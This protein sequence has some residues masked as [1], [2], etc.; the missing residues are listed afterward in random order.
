MNFRTGLFVGLIA[1]FT[2]AG[3]VGYFFG[4]PILVE[5][6]AGAVITAGALGTRDGA[7]WLRKR[8]TASE[9]DTTIE[10]LENGNADGSDTPNDL[11]DDVSDVRDWTNL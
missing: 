8:R 1:G 11:R 2:I 6:V 9:T 4:I 10:T 7:E 3:V 5:A